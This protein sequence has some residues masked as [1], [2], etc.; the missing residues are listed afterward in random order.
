MFGRKLTKDAE[1]FGGVERIHYKCLGVDVKD[2]KGFL[3]FPGED[4]RL[5]Q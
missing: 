2:V 3:D 1:M 4:R 5:G